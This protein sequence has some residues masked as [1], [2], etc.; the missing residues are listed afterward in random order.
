LMSG[1]RRINVTLNGEPTE[2]VA[3]SHDTLTDLL[4]LER[5]YGNRESCGIGVCG[6]CTVLVD[7]RAVA[8]C[9]VLAQVLDGA[10]IETIEGIGRPGRLSPLQQAFIDESAL[11]CGFCTPGMVLTATQLLRENPAP[12][13]EEIAHFLA[14]NICRCG[15]YPEIIRAVR[16]AAKAAAGDPIDRSDAGE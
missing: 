6:V 10:V 11:Q 12:S 15:A 1:E 8:G 4:R 16:A 7:Q 13:D 2:L 3:E 14:G 9:L 5:L